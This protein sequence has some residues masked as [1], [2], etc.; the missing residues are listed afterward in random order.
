VGLAR[1]ETLPN[2]ARDL[3]AVCCGGGSLFH[4][5]IGKK[6]SIDRCSNLLDISWW[7]HDLDSYLKTLQYYLDCFRSHCSVVG[8]EG[9]GKVTPTLD[10]EL[11]ASICA[12]VLDR[13]VSQRSTQLLYSTSTFRP[14]DMY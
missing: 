11:A 5:S 2:V 9:S 14:D 13:L 6:S 4:S 8:S 7:R 10:C 3:D 1:A 12:T